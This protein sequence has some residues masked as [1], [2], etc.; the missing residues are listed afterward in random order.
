MGI[1]L[2]KSS[3]SMGYALVPF[4]SNERHLAMTDEEHRRAGGV[5]DPS[6]DYPVYHYSMEDFLRPP[7]N[8]SELVKAY[9]RPY[10]QPCEAG[11][12]LAAL[13]HDALRNVWPFYEE[14]NEEQPKQAA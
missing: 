5:R 3:P 8:S 10:H 12:L 13:E 6:Y 11:A 14:L 2:E 4:P 7:E 9:Q 1:A